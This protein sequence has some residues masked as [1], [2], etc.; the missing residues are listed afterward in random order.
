MKLS[1]IAS[2][3]VFLL[4]LNFNA[5][6]KGGEETEI[7]NF[8]S[9]LGSQIINLVNYPEFARNLMGSQE[10]IIHFTVDENYQIHMLDTQGSN[11]RLSTYV[12][13]MLEGKEV[14]TST[15]RINKDFRIKLVFK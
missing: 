14:H 13:S 12:K 10:V 1:S 8:G 3:F 4:T 9:E 7:R 11:A 2:T 5:L 6:A 15:D